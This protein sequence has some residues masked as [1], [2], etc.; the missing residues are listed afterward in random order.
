LAQPDTR[1]HPAMTTDR[2][3]PIRNQC[4]ANMKTLP[5]LPVQSSPNRTTVPLTQKSGHFQ[6]AFTG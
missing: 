5:A 6:A 3:A 2:Q 1:E 4:V